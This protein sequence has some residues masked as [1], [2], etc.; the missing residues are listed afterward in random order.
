MYTKRQLFDMWFVLYNTALRA[1][2][3]DDGLYPELATDEADLA[4]EE[5]LTKLT[6]QGYNTGGIWDAE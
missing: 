2:S 5:V 6:E 1:I 4:F 3:D